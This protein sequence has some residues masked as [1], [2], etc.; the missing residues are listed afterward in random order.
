M[1]D[2]TPTIFHF[3]E[4]AWDDVFSRYEGQQRTYARRLNISLSSNNHEEGPY[5]VDDISI[6]DWNS[7]TE[8]L[9][10][11]TGLIN[12]SY[13]E[14]I[15]VAKYDILEVTESVFVKDNNTP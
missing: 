10:F 1:L 14:A 2:A 7:S 8:E 11:T 5:S 12:D 6:I 3:P 13:H 4:S 15:I 9:T